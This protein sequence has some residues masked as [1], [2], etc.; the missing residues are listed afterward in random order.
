MTDHNFEDHLREAMHRSTE[1]LSAPPLPSLRRRVRTRQVLIAFST[2]VAIGVIGVAGAAGVNALRDSTPSGLGPA[3]GDEQQLDERGSGGISPCETLYTDYRCVA[4]GTYGDV[5]WS[6]GAE[7]MPLRTSLASKPK[8]QLCMTQSTESPEHGGSASAVGGGGCM[9]Y[10]PDRIGLSGLGT[11]DPDGYF[12]SGYVGSSIVRA[13]VETGS[14]DEISLQLYPAPSDFPI[15]DVTFFAVFLPSDATDVVGY[16]DSGAVI[17]RRSLALAAANGAL[18]DEAESALQA[19]QA[20]QAGFVPVDHGEIAGSPWALGARLGTLT[21]VTGKVS[22]HELCASLDIE[23]RGGGANCSAGVPSEFAFKYSRIDLVQEPGVTVILGTISSDVD[24][25]FVEF[26]GRPRE[27]GY[28]VDA[29]SELG[30]DIRLFTAFFEAGDLGDVSGTIH[31]FDRRGDPLGQSTIC[32]ASEGND[33]R[34]CEP[35]EG[36]IP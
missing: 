19:L 14:G 33:V 31:A 1:H 24:R 23:G 28:I 36:A 21:P 11:N 27:Q 3:G 26:D 12:T 29:P 7:M 30:T 16:D 35:N 4:N 13:V 34:V 20:Y 32:L 18:I 15:N 10:H 5:V 9:V 25:I 17:D 6:I 2:V 8:D 22:G